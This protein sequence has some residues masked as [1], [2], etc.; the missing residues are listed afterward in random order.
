MRLDFC[1]VVRQYGS[2]MSQ[3]RSSSKTTPQDRKAAILQAVLELIAER[4]F[5]DTPMS[6]ITQRS[7]ASAGIIYH[8][9]E[10]KDELI[11]ALYAQVKL[12]YSNALMQHNPQNLSAPQAF[13][14]LWLN[15][16]HHH[17]DHPQETLFMEQYEN[18][19]YFERH[20]HVQEADEALNQMLQVLNS[21]EK[22]LKDL[23]L[24][25]LWEL[26]MGVAARVARSEHL[27]GSLD[28]DAAQLDL[29][30]LACW[31]AISN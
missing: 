5:H 3:T 22:G 11:H 13:R 12:Q 21:G 30:A 14:Q 31:Q 18:S 26:S 4:G 1:N 25:V 28:L 2:N 8:Y 6:M 9:F 29:I 15:A 19:P 17:R 27:T 23:P 10:N 20:R 16:Y 24:D 7:G